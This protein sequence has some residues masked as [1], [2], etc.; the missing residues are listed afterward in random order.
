MA[1]IVINKNFTTSDNFWHLN[2]QL[3]YIK[4]FADLYSV[5]KSKGKIKSSNDMWCIFFMEEQDEEFNLFF[6]IPKEDRLK[7]LKE[8]YNLEFDEK[9]P[10]VVLCCESYS[11]FILTAIE[12]SLKDMKELLTK[13]A[14]TLLNMEYNLDTMKSIDDSLSKNLKIYEDFKKTQEAFDK[15]KKEIKA[16]GQRNLT[17]SEQGRL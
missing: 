15:T 7:M 16:R 10:L 17:L 14:K 12:R 5:D 9:N 11:E 2:P 6:R 3:I 1:T 13:R 8:V 4:P